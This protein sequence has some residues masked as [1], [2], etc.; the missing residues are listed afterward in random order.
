MDEVFPGDLDPSK[1]PIE[2][3]RYTDT[4]EVDAPNG[5]TYHFRDYEGAE[6][7]LFLNFKDEIVVT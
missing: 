6:D 1:L 2:F 5:E 4:F 3:N 7:F